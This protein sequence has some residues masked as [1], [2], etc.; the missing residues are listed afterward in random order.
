MEALRLA[1]GDLFD[2]DEPG[3]VSPGEVRWRVHL[4]SPPRVA[5]FLIATAEGRRRFWADSARERDGVLELRFTDGRI[6]R[7]RVREREPFRRFALEL[8]GGALL[9]F[10]LAADGLGG[11]D[12][13]LTETGV[14]PTDRDARADHHE[15][16]AAWA[17]L[18]LALK[19]A[20]D[21]GVDLRHHDPRRS[22]DRGYVD[23]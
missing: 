19:A 15:R 4:A 11:T 1:L 3:A 12:L 18:L 2:M 20:A 22:R 6:L 10:D 23:V 5:Y 17:A 7:G 21:F 16:R 13:T 9:A 14:P 8:A